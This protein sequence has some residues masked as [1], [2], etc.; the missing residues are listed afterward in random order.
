MKQIGFIG[1]GTM[2][3]PMASN[4]LRGG[5]QVTVYN[6]TAAKCEPL[7]AEGALSASTPQDAA[8]GKDIIMTMISNDDSI[9]EVF[10]GQ[11]GILEALKPGA[12]IIDSST[13]SPGLVR[14]IAA[15]VEERGGK[16]LDAPVTG[17]KPAAVEG[18]LVF[19]VG[20]SAEVIEEHRDIFDSMGRLLLHM[21]DN[22]SG[23]VAK[24]A[25]NAMVGIHNVALAEGFSIAVKSGVPA[26]KFLELVQNGSAGS[27]QAELKGRK[28]IEN[29]FS[30]QFSL[31]LMLKDLKLASSLSDSTGVPSPMLGLAKSMFQAGYTQGYGD[32]DLSA[33]VKCYEEW[34][35]QKIGAGASQ[36]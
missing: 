17:S 19:M 25:H 16:F 18:T 13:I 14:E 35:G 8:E 28:I 30:N 4:L 29:D 9:R 23:A 34:I 15:A 10:Y 21:G 26:D 6:R 7:V 36:E 11:G 24:L 27:K 31:A 33:V 1:L 32:E 22:G 2:G 12:V 5:F 3:A 20:G